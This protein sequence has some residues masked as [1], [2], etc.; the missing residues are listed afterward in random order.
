MILENPR[1]NWNKKIKE[2]IR[3]TYYR[4]RAIFTKS[5][6][7]SHGECFEQ[8]PESNIAFLETSYGA[9]MIEPHKGG[10]TKPK[11]MKKL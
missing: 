2:K 10:N 5:G 7:T 1:K 8:H 4:C 6:V 3:T 9:K 11:A